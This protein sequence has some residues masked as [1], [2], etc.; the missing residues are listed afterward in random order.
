M[1]KS[2][3]RMQQYLHAERS[4][5]EKDELILQ[6][7]RTVSL[8]KGEVGQTDQM[9][10]MEEL[11][12]TAKAIGAKI[13]LHGELPKDREVQKILMDAMRECLTNTIQ[14]AG[15]DCLHVS[16]Y[17]DMTTVH[18]DLTNNGNKPTAS[19]TEGGGLSS[20]RQKIERAGGT[21]KITIDG[22]F[23]LSVSIPDKGGVME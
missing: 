4:Q 2:V 14:H 11:M 5:E 8:L 20:L 12:D 19:I 6:L 17:K 3:L 15:G 7:K 1:G 13:V 18:A 16:V 21:M 23:C 22:G 10:P 9:N